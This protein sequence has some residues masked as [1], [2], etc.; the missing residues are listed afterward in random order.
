VGFDQ[1]ERDELSEADTEEKWSQPFVAVP[2]RLLF[3]SLSQFFFS[4]TLTFSHECTFHVEFP[5]N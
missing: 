2:P 4:P 1:F 5:P 3:C